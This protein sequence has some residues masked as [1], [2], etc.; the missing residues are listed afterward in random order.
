MNRINQC[1]IVWVAMVLLTGCSGQPVRKDT[2]AM[3]PGGEVAGGDMQ[4]EQG[5]GSQPG[6]TFYERNRSLIKDV[7]IATLVVTEIALFWYLVDKHH[8][9]D[10]AFYWIDPLWPAWY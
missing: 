6:E 8:D 3:T 1:I 10:M 2:Q 9:S 4:A 7:F 5:F